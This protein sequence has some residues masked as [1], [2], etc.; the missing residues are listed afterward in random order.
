M[1]LKINQAKRKW[2]YQPDGERT[3]DCLSSNE[4]ALG[5]LSVMEKQVEDGHLEGVLLGISLESIKRFWVK[6]ETIR[7]ALQGPA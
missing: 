4:A 1:G 7:G 2:I 6:L 3:S 5:L